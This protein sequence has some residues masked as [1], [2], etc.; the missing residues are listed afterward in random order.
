M[1]KK[2][3]K[4]DVILASASPRRKE[5]LKNIFNEFRIIPADI[6]ESTN[7]DTIVEKYPEKIAELKAKA[8]AGEFFNS[9]VIGC[10]TAVIVDE[11]M[12]GKP[13][14][15]NDAIRM[16]KSLSGRKHKVITGCCLCYKG[17]VHCFS[18]VTEVEFYQL[19]E[20][21]IMEYILEEEKQSE[22]SDIKYQWEDKAGGY[23]IQGSAGLLIKG[24]NG[25]YNNVV[26]LPVAE[27]NR[28]IKR[29]I[30]NS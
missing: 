21:E 13:K 22:N 27:L 18:S 11:Q 15:K 1:R 23:G 30:K 19:E 5:L 10:D 2:M 26:G 4:I 14:D 3:Q 6:D 8:I 29:F 28:Q 20:N 24:I 25:D 12:Y 7:F 9:L 16:I 17:K